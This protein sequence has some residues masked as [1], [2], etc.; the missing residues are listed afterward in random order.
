MALGKIPAVWRQHRY[1]S[2]LRYQ[3]SVLGISGEK[4]K[5][6]WLQYSVGDAA[7]Y[8]AGTESFFF[9]FFWKCFSPL[10]SSCSQNWLGLH[11]ISSGIFF[12]PFLPAV[13]SRLYCRERERISSGF[14]GPWNGWC[15]L[16]ALQLRERRSLKSLWFS[17][18]ILFSF[19]LY[20]K[21]CHG[22]RWCPLRGRYCNW[23]Q[24]PTWTGLPRV[25]HTAKQ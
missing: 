11:N 15:E 21:K 7:S 6:G 13:E 25:E 8:L 14:P 3:L 18:L 20:G 2:P 9:F 24:P 1:P 17:D 12:S 4:Q 10:L 22:D 16:W 23:G 19:A 5:K